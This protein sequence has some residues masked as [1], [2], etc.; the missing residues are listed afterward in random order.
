MNRPAFLLTFAAFVASGVLAAVMGYRALAS[1]R[2]GAGS[3]SV[4]DATYLRVPTDSQ[5]DWMTT[6]TLTE[7]S[8]KEVQWDD[9]D[10]RVRVTSFFF[11]SCPSTC[12]QQNY[13][14]REIQQHFAGQDVVFL[15]ITCDPDVDTPQ[16][17]SE[18]AQ[19]LGA[20]KQ[21]WLFLTGDLTYIRRVASEL[22]SVAMDKH[23]HSERFFVHDK[24]GNPRGSF[25][26]NK[27]DE[28]TQ[29]KLQVARLLDETEEPAELK[30]TGD[31][32]QEQ[33]ADPP[34]A[35]DLK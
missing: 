31:G 24:W 19:Q 30:R 14:F 9:L 5:A 2:E 35:S 13:K 28:T 29:L 6:F 33:P 32:R 20:D 25:L 11:T 12:L 23:V 10:G 22:F 3:M 8:G 18:Y 7:R 27:L 26:W 16:R 17:L 1:M 34:A 21:Q 4:V 15:S